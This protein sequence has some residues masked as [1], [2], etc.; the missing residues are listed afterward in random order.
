MWILL[1]SAA[2]VS[3]PTALLAGAHD[4]P[5]E[6]H[7]VEAAKT[8]EAHA[9]LAAH[10]REKAAEARAA[11]ARHRSMASAYGRGK[12]GTRT[13]SFHCDRL[14]EREAAAAAEY[15]ELA[16]LHDAAAHGAH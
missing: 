11:S 15:E 14:S 16:K 9:A 1:L 8:P 10:F 13:G 5:L 12:Q 7:A 3:A 6:E 4:D 2:L